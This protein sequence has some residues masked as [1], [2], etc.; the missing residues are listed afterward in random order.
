MPST[1]YW[2]RLYTSPLRLQ[3]L[4]TNANAEGYACQYV[5]MLQNVNLSEP[6]MLINC[7]LT[8]KGSKSV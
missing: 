6:G 1:Q 5:K 7:I 3:E 8:G 2:Q 4:S